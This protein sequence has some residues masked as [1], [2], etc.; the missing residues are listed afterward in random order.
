VPSQLHEVLVMLF[1]NRPE[2]APLLLQEALHVELPKYTEVRIES[3]KLTDVVPAEYSADLVVLLVDGRPVLGI[4]VEVQLK[5]DERKRFS[6][7]VYVA[8]L[9]A[10]LECDC[11][12]LVVCPT[13]K[14]ALWS[15]MPI[16]TG[17]GGSLMPL[18]L[19]PEGVPVV[20]DGEKA[21]RFPE[22]AVLSVMAHGQGDVQT[23]VNIA[24]VAAAAA[25]DLASDSQALYL[26]LIESAL[27]GAA[28][29][30]FE[31][32]PET[33][34]FQGPSYL[35]GRVEGEANG[36]AE[37]ILAILEARGMPVANDQRQRI[38]DCTNVDRLNAWVRRAVT[39]TDV[40]ELFAQ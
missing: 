23:A 7:P 11:C 28:R 6:W 36:K 10:R 40:N 27:G 8:G 19:G 18:V 38:L 26:D 3:A 25:A 32:L 1:R 37:D 39:L 13:T 17:P 12:L 31:M 9:R 20:T 16:A 33:Y 22:L 15:S 34:Q 14:T 2:L 29:K 5:P 4:I 30:A 35:R 21:R 24:R